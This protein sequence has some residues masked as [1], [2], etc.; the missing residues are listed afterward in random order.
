MIIPRY[1]TESY[2]KYFHSKK[3]LLKNLENYDDRFDS[4][5]L[6]NP[7]FFDLTRKSK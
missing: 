3:D 1:T 7:K 2:E 6:Y 4:I 5:S